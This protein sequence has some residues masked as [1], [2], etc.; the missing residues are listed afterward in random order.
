MPHLAFGGLGAILDFGQQSWFNPDAAMR[1]PLRIGLGLADQRH[2]TLAQLSG[3]VL[4]EAMVDLARVNQILAL[5][6]S[7]IDA[8]PFLAVERKTGNG[9]ASHAAGRSS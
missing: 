7:E 3:G 1:N 6:A 8:V 4:V 9:S 2:Q 5:A